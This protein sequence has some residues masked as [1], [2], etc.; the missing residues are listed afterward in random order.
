MT[1]PDG[2]EDVCGARNA[3]RVGLGAAIMGVAVDEGVVR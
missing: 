2:R 3:V 1:M